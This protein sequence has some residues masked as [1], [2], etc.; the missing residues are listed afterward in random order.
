ML[1][2]L[3]LT[4]ER[5]FQRLVGNWRGKLRNLLVW[6]K[7]GRVPSSGDFEEPVNSYSRDSR[8][9]EENL[10]TDVMRGDDTV[11]SITGLRQHREKLA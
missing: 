9:R 4:L 10:N 3:A 11:S 8:Q 6:E 5:I 7:R 2:A 1:K